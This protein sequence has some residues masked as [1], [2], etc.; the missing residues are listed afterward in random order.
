MGSRMNNAEG[1]L[2][3][4]RLRELT[5]LSERL[6]ELESEILNTADLWKSTLSN[7]NKIMFCGNG[8]FAAEAQHLAAELTGHY[9]IERDPLPGLALTVDTSALTAIGN[10]YGFDSI[11]ERQVRAYGNSGD[12]LVLMSTSGNS[13]N[14]TN[15]VNA[16]KA[17]GIVTLAITG[18]SGALQ[19]SCD[20]RISINSNSPGR[21]QEMT[22][23]I[24]HTLCELIDLN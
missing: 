24:G 15:A 2:F 8:G 21:I 18:T 11:Y 7:G 6:Q 5:T 17:L 1:Q 4:S 23:F 10:D 20:Y 22:L 19:S 13:P 12:L 16:A 9:M 14:L 3:R